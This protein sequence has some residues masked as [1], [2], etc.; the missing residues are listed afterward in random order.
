MR[1]KARI[2][3][4]QPVIVAAYRGRG[5]SV[6]ILSRVGTGCPDLAVG[7]LGVTDM[8]EVKNEGGHLTADQEIWHQ[9]W[10]GGLRVVR[11]LEDVGE[12]VKDMKR[13]AKLCR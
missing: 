13:R 1:Q 6:E 9:T 5:C 2:D 3:D 8:V 12:H 7:I 11:T 10:R 4:N